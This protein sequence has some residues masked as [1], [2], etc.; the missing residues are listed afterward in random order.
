[1]VSYGGGSRGG[2]V[3]PRNAMNDND[4]TPVVLDGDGPFLFPRAR[5]LSVSV[6]ADDVILHLATIDE[7]TVEVPIA[8]GALPDLAMGIAAALRVLK[9]E[10]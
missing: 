5:V 1:M 7:Q 6:T 9:P 8:I 2:G 10:E 3:P 4:L